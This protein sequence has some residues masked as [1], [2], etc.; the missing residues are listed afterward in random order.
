MI[1]FNHRQFAIKLVQNH[2]SVLP[3]IHLRKLELIY[4]TYC[5]NKHDI[6]GCFKS[7]RYESLELTDNY[8]L[9]RKRLQS[10]RTQPN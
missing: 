10:S 2:P 5:P 8:I 1:K 4:T 9:L 6:K 3:F 7:F